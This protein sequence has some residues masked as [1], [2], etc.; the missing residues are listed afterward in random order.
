ML[1]SL[2]SQLDGSRVLAGSRQLSENSLQ[3]RL[4]QPVDRSL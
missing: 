2:Q 3:R 4:I 1:W